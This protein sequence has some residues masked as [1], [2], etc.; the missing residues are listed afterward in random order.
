MYSELST[1]WGGF[2]PNQIR[3]AT[4][5]NQATSLNRIVEYD[6]NGQAINTRTDADGIWNGKNTNVQ[7]VVLP[8]QIIE[9]TI[10]SN[11]C[12]NN[13]T[14]SIDFKFP[15]LN[16]GGIRIDKIQIPF[17]STNLEMN[18]VNQEI[19][20][21]LDV[22][23]VNDQGVE[24]GSLSLTNISEFVGEND[25][26]KLIIYFD[27]L[28]Q[29]A[30]WPNN[31]LSY[32]S[33]QGSDVQNGWVMGPEEVNF[34][35]RVHFRFAENALDN[36]S[37]SRIYGI[38]PNDV[39]HNFVLIEFSP[40]CTN[41]ETNSTSLVPSKIYLPNEDYILHGGC[42]ISSWNTTTGS[43]PIELHFE[44]QFSSSGISNPLSF[45]RNGESLETA[46]TTSCLKYRFYFETDMSS[47]DGTQLFD[48]TNGTYKYLDLP[49]GATSFNIQ[50]GEESE[51]AIIEGENA[52]YVEIDED[53]G[54]ISKQ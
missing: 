16:D 25:E 53:E 19:L 14:Y 4:G 9:H 1:S 31:G 26:S 33:V 32:S 45:Y 48:Q 15:A 50:I 46:C 49:T 38:S 40:P 2:I 47:T 27:D 34:R 42:D 22:V 21:D 5:P 41:S 54:R 6:W 11:A 8:F 28:D 35:V 20:Y 23:Y 43:V 44:Y 17:L 12:L 52:F 10:N 51:N 13:Y 39:S 36:C 24:S 18:T 30:M 7:D 3:Y 37:N 29:S